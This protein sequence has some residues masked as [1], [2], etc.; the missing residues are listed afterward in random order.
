MKRIQNIFNLKEKV[1][2][3]P[4]LKIFFLSSPLHIFPIHLQPGLLSPDT[5][6]LLFA[7]LASKVK[8][9]ISCTIRTHFREK[10]LIP[11]CTKN[12]S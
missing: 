2:M 7:D 4:S 8:N 5:Q 10:I 6:L 12:L 11:I 3:T 1:K 9:T